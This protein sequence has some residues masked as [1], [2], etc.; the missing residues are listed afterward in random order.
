VDAPGLPLPALAHP[1]QPPGRKRGGH[2]QEREP[3]ELVGLQPRPPPRR[4]LIRPPPLPRVGWPVVAPA[5]PRPGPRARAGGPGPLPRRGPRGPGGELGVSLR[6]LLEALL[7]PRGQ[8]R[9]ELRAGCVRGVTGRWRPRNNVMY[10]TKRPLK[11]SNLGS[12]LRPRSAF[13]SG[14]EPSS[15]PQETWCAGRVD[16]SFLTLLESLWNASRMSLALAPL[17]T[18]STSQG[19]RCCARD[20]IALPVHRSWL[21]RCEV[22]AS[23]GAS[24]PVPGRGAP[25]WPPL[26]ACRPLVG[27]RREAEDPPPRTSRHRARHGVR[28]THWVPAANL[29]RNTGAR[30]MRLPRPQPRLLTQEVTGAPPARDISQQRTDVLPLGTSTFPPLP[31]ARDGR[32]GIVPSTILTF[33]H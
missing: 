14:S 1:P 20:A 3:Q 27:G 17:G 24:P 4:P 28:A 2:G 29:C 21:V 9:V 19:H 16:V 31:A 32:S 22:T 26:T 8:V 5:P 18:P 13:A 23:E 30:P 11:A 6:D 33:T 10:V 7:V 25:L 12:I 15:L